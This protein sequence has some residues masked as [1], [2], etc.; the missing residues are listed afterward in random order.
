MQ[1]CPASC[2]ASTAYTPPLAPPPCATSESHSAPSSSSEEGGGGSAC[3]L[4]GARPGEAPP[5]AERLPRTIALHFEALCVTRFPK[6][7]F[8]IVTAEL[9]AGM[10]VRSGVM[11]VVASLDADVALVGFTGRNGPREDVSIMGSTTDLSLREGKTS[12]LVVKRGGPHDV[13]V[14]G[15]DGSRRALDAL[16]F[17]LWLDG[18]DHAAELPAHSIA[19]FL[20]GS[21]QGDPL[22]LHHRN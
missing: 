15:V 6:K 7:R 2:S 22:P 4:P 12:T 3:A 18:A 5:P 13:V 21:P 20:H 19:T 9:P 17:A 16:R 8:E 11:E 10:P 14:V 1:K